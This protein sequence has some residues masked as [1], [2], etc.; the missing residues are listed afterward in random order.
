MDLPTALA[1]SCDTYFYQLGDRFYDLPTSRGQPLQK[2]ATHLRVRQDDGRRRRPRGGGPRCPTIGWRQRTY[3]QQTDPR[4]ADRPALEAGRLDPARDR[5]EGP[6]RDAAPD[7][8]LL[9][10][11]RERRQARHAA[12]ADGRREPERR[13]R[14]RSRAPARAAEDQRRPGRAAGRPRRASARRRTSSFGTSYGVFGNFPVPIA[15]KT[16]TAEKIVT[17]P[18]YTGLQNQSW[19]C[20][21]GPT[22]NAEAR[23]LRRD[24]ERRPRRHGG[25]AGGEQVFASSSTS[26]LKFGRPST[27]TE[28]DRAHSD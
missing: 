11:D 25:R 7:G 24:R 12:R 19:W 5:P 14:R 6:A 28:A 9:R 2:W 16:G 20:G 15:G 10:A 1:Y 23:R 27:P 18:G 21:Y 3:T 17:L 22:D 26:R 4:L 13:R 8:A